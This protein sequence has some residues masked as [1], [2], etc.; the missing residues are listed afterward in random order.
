MTSIV[1]LNAFGEFRR[2]I[3]YSVAKKVIFSK[4]ESKNVQIYDYDNT[5]SS[6]TMSLDLMSGWIWNSH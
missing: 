5:N 6:I 4:N 2:S 1:S 3:C